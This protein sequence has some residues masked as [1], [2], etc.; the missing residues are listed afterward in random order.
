MQTMSPLT[1]LLNVA[2]MAGL[3]PA[4]YG[5]VAC[6]FSPT[7]FSVFYQRSRRWIDRS[8]GLIFIAFGA[9]LATDS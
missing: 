9:R 2:L 4:W 8:A 1:I 3:S 6:L 5:V 7:P